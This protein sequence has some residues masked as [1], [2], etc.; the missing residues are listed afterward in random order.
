M[1]NLEVL[2]L[3]E[4]LSKINDRKNTKF[5]YLI[6]RNKKIIKDTVEA[7]MA[8]QIQK[9][10]GQDSFDKDRMNLCRAYAKKDEKGNP[11]LVQ[12]AGTKVKSF[13]IEDMEGFNADMHKLLTSNRHAEYRENLERKTKEFDELL[14]CEAADHGQ[15]A[16]ISLDDLPDDLTIEEL[17]V[18]EQ[19][20]E[21]T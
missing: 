3:W 4:R 12:F 15:F 1:K 9:I 10:E 7:L 16:K 11:T 19:F 2:V 14:Q 21:E 20:I 13:D 5:S 18:I 8:I 17:E 6:L